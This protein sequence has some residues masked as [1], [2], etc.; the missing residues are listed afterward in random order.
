MKL[1]QIRKRGKF[2]MSMVKKE[3]SNQK[4]VVILEAAMIFSMT[5]SIIEAGVTINID[6]NNMRICSRIQM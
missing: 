5:S 6:S 3:S 4:L 2:T 1:F